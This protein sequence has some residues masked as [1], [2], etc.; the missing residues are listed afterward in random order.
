MN[1]E[2]YPSEGYFIMVSTAVTQLGS[3]DLAADGDI[4]L[5][6]IRIYYKN[7]NP[8]NHQIRLVLSTN[9]G[10]AA[11]AAS[12]WETLSNETTG[13]ST[14]YWLVDLTFTF[15]AYPLKASDRYYARL[16]ITNYTRDQNE[17]YMGIW[18][19]WSEP[20]GIADTAGARIALGVLR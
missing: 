9:F 7:A 20:V 17:V 18:V 6:H 10:G 19:D 8:Y 1:I 11:V 16:E 2:N 14:E 12:N 13:Q 4:K 3:Y 15:D 5:A